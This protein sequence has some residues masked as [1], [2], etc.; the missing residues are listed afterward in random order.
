MR[1]DDGGGRNSLT[2]DEQRVVDYFA[3]AGG[4]RT[5]EEIVSGV[6]RNVFN[7]DAVFDADKDLYYDT[8]VVEAAVHSL[9][10]KELLQEVGSA[11]HNRLSLRLVRKGVASD[12]QIRS[13]Q[14]GTLPES[15]PVPHRVDLAIPECEDDR[16]EFKETFSVPVKDAKINKSN[17]IKEEV[18]IAVAAFANTE[19]GRLFIGVNDDGKPVGLKK[20]LRMYKSL[21]G[22]QSAIRSSVRDHLGVLVDMKFGFSGEQYLVIEIPARRPRWVYVNSDFY[23]RYGNTSPRLNTQETAEYLKEYG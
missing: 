22:L 16:N 10:E 18:A 3:K 12:R 20:D 4:D 1:G 23:V 14:N 19:G 11:M 7:L 2:Y 8:A 9:V 6:D 5:M 17:K 13:G 21:D 15:D